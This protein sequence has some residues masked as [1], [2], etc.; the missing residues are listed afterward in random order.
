M[1]GNI[2][3]LNLEG[4]QIKN[5]E[6]IERLYSLEKLDLS[7]NMIATLADVSGLANLPEL[8]HLQL[9][10]NPLEKDGIKKSYRLKLLN[11]FKEARLDKSNKSLTYRDILGMMPVINDIVVTNK[12]LVAMRN[13]TFSQSLATNR[14][15]VDESLSQSQQIG[16]KD[17]SIRLL[18]PFRDEYSGIAVTCNVLQPQGHRRTIRKIQRRKVS[19]L[20]SSQQD[21]PKSKKK[22]NPT[23]QLDAEKKKNSTDIFLD[24]YPTVETV[25]VSLIAPNQTKAVEAP[26]SYEADASTNVENIEENVDMESCSSGLDPCDSSE[27]TD[28]GE[29]ILDQIDAALIDPIILYE[30][31][32]L[33]PEPDP[34][35]ID[36]KDEDV[37]QCDEEEVLSTDQ[38]VETESQKEVE[39]SETLREDS[40]QYSPKKAQET[41][42]ET[43]NFAIAERTSTYDGPNEYTDLQVLSYLELYFKCF[44]FPQSSMQEVTM[45]DGNFIAVKESMLVPRIQLYQSDRDLMMWTRT[46]AQSKEESLSPQYEDNLERLVAV[47]SEKVIPCGIAASG[48]IPPVESE[49]KGIRGGTM[50]DEGKPLVMSECQ[51]LLLCISTDAIYFISENPEKSLTSEEA[52]RRFPS[53]IPKQTKFE[54][55]L[56]PHAYCRHP[57]KFLKKITFDGFGFQRLTLHFKLPSVRGE[58]FVQPESGG[59]LS[60]FDYTYVI[61]TCNQ[62]RTIQLM[63]TLQNTIK[64]ASLESH[65]AT[66]YS[67]D[68][69]KVE[70]DDHAV[71]VAIGN[72][73]G[74]KTFNDDILHYQILHQIMQPADMSGPRRALV[75]TNERI[76]LIHETYTGDGFG[77]AFVNDES[78]SNIQSGDVVMKVVAN[79]K[80]DN[81]T[82]TCVLDEDSRKVGITIK[83]KSGLRRTSRW[84]L[85]CKDSE[86]AEKAVHGIRRAL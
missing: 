42:M 62:K 18:E 21:I 9:H 1:M 10:G 85:L 20:H 37:D 38:S 70:N 84:L 4:N 73:L 3:V 33:P 15:E 27:S 61:M 83:T 24:R 71:Q 59:L 17:P 29:S 55:A 65:G 19:I 50:F 46:L 74:P 28:L 63:Q 72:A 23:L 54:Q 30:K 34:C 58:V 6:G 13:F 67:N 31:I 32:E 45:L 77:S 47:T 48:R 53:P 86:S 25:F 43:F 49:V 7:K 22:K 60:A 5:V 78:A 66:N 64:E 36:G 11:L 80:L 35:E 76:I 69:L 51:N 56:W 14:I 39:Q 26:M 16:P 40:K 2:Q 79:T 8:M 12:E 41:L 52:S 82:E 75:V 44:V 81:L 68:L 57:L